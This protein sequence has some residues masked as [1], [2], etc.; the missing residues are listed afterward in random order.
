MECVSGR[1]MLEKKM[2]V[3]NIYV[4]LHI[5]IYY[6]I[7]IFNKLL[8]LRLSA[9]TSRYCIRFL[10]SLSAVAISRLHELTSMTD[11]SL[12][13]ATYSC[14]SLFSTALGFIGFGIRCCRFAQEYKSFAKYLTKISNDDWLDIVIAHTSE[15]LSM[16][17]APIE[18]G[19]SHM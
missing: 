3:N 15:G 17:G 7:L 2:F 16:T 19:L 4:H 6:F 10:P 14:H 8:A 18:C 12:F 13:I 5:C 1:V 9:S 11:I